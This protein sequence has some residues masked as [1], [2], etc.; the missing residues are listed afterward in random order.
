MGLA[1]MP[2][3]WTRRRRGYRAILA[4]DPH[5][6]DALYLLGLVAHQTGSHEQ[7]AHLFR[8]ALSVQP[9]DTPCWN[10]L[11]LALSA[12]GDAAGA[13]H[14]FRQALA[15]AESADYF[16]NLGDDAQKD[17]RAMEAAAAYRDALRINPSFAIA[18]YS[19]GNLHCLAGEL[20]DAAACFER[21]VDAAPEHGDSLA[22]LGRTLTTLGRPA[23]ALPFLERALQQMP[24]DPEL[25]CDLGDALAAMGRR[26]EAAAAYDRA[27]A[28]QPDLARAWFASA[29]MARDGDEFAAA[30]ERFRQAARLRPQWAEAL[31][32]LGYALFHTGQSGRSAGCV[33]SSIGGG[34][35]KRL[36]FAGRG[37]C[38]R[39]SPS[40][41]RDHPGCQAG[42]GAQGASG[43][44]SHIAAQ[45]PRRTFAHRL[46][47]GSLPQTD[48]DETGMGRDSRARPRE[49]P[50]PPVFRYAGAHHRRGVPPPSGRCLPRYFRAFQFGTPRS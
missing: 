3:N 35:R 10:L 47:F 20:Q 38:A 16:V 19:L 25:A 33:R 37:H 42:L 17:G 28:G 1:I 29:C 34:Q 41:K 12:E 14:S 4:R 21:A 39:Q 49:R 43:C 26:A 5:Q 31:H 36:A 44:P 48:L 23:D 8:Q 30:A 2:G 15:I 9:A 50:G 7:A 46:Y 24:R 18:H 32:N 22:A 40:D 27:L 6:P 13:E 45:S 11:G